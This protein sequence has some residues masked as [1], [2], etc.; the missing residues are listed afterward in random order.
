MQAYMPVC[1]RCAGMYIGIFLSAVLILLFERK[2]RT[3]FSGRKITAI[4]VILFAAMA[5]ESGLSSLKIIPSYNTARFLTGYAVG[6]FLPLFILPLLNSVVFRPAIC[7]QEQYLKKA[8]HFIIWIFSGLALG[9][10]FLVTYKQKILFWSIASVAGLV[11]FIAALILILVFA[12]NL[13]LRNTVQNPAVFWGFFLAAIAISLAFISLS[14]YLKSI[15]NPY[16]S[17][18]YEYLRSVYGR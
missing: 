14:S 10:I 16:I 4:T 2:I 11:L 1:S 13:K 7:L 6:W 17:I 3:Q 18:S 9:F 8:G 5:A 12:V 15:I